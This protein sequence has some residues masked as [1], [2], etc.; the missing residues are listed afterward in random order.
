MAIRDI[1]NRECVEIITNDGVEFLRLDDTIW[2]E[3]D[4]IRDP[5]RLETMYQAY[6][7]AR[8]D[9]SDKPASDVGS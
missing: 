1:T 4:F 7:T 3:M 6:L 5:A 8:R 2:I 9:P